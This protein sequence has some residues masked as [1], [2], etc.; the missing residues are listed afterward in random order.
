[1][2]AVIGDVSGKGAEAAAIL[3]LARYIIRAAATSKRCPSAIL[4]RL[5]ET[6]LLQRRERGDHKFCTA[7]YIKLQPNK[8]EAEHH[9]KVTIS[10][11]RHPPPVLLKADGSILKIGQPGH[12]I[13]VFEEAHLT[14]QEAR[15]AAGDALVLYTDGVLEARAE[16]GT[17][18]GEEPLMSILRSS[19]ALDASTIAGRIERAVVDF[20]EENL[21][22]DI[23]VLVLPVPS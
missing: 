7:A 6:M 16:D 17:F 23:A 21:R 20:Q 2:G 18:F 11:G 15:L 9:T 14:E 22:D 1:M 5:N 19:A 13:G 3:A 10:C 4:A 8:E 12:A